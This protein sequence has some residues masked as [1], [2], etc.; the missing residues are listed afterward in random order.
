MFRQEFL[1]IDLDYD[2]FFSDSGV[3]IVHDDW[4]VLSL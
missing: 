2:N 1:Q 4:F 3:F